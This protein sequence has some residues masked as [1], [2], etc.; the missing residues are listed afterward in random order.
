MQSPELVRKRKRSLDGTSFRFERKNHA[1][2]VSDLPVQVRVKENGIVELR[3]EGKTVLVSSATHWEMIDDDWLPT[4]LSAGSILAK[5]DEL[6]EYLQ[7]AAQGDQKRAG[8]KNA[9]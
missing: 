5:Y 7:H 2:W 4:P 9:I 1:V 6:V 3:M 8:E